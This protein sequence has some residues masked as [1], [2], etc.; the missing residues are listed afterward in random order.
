MAGRSALITGASSGIG[1]A[2]AVTLARPGERLWL[3][4]ANDEAGVDETA[5]LCEELGAA[6][7][8]SRLDLRTE[9]SIAQLAREVTTAWGSL[10]VLV[11]AAEFARTSPW[12]RS[13]ST[14]GIASSRPTPV[15]TSSNSRIVALLRAVAPD[16]RSVVNISSI[17]GQTGVIQTGA[18]DAASKAAILGITGTLARL[19]ATEGIRVMRSVLDRSSVV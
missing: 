1:A 19:L 11:N 16:D 5:R 6:V 15:G 3:T 2:V 13:P 12:M 8:T 7:M 10:D 14:T 18:H 4:Y 17:A 9:S